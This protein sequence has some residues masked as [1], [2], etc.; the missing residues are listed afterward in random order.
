MFFNYS[1]IFEPGGWLLIKF[2]GNV[3][4]LFL[5]KILEPGIQHITIYNNL[6]TYRYIFICRSIFVIL[7]I[8]IYLSISQL[9]IHLTIYPS[10]YLS[11]CI[12]IYSCAHEFMYRVSHNPWDTLHDVI[13]MYYMI[14]SDMYACINIAIRNINWIM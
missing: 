1:V 11:V 8:S 9:I 12:F 10:N 3:N 14:L 4:Y 5:D 6:T 13:I 2:N 7:Y